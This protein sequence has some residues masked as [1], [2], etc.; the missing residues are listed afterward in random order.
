MSDEAPE[1]PDER[2]E[3]LVRVS[4][5]R[6]SDGRKV[7]PDAVGAFDSIHPVKPAR[8]GEAAV[9]AAQFAAQ[10]LRG[11]TQL[12]TQARVAVRDAARRPEV[13]RGVAILGA[14][15]REGARVLEQRVDEAARKIVAVRVDEGAE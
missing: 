6:V 9:Q 5:R 4:V 1:H 14:A 3:V 7:A 13:R 11:P 8:L 15:L 10:G 2:Y 12:L